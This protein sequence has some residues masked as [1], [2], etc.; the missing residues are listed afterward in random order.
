MYDGA[1][2][3]LVLKM[4]QGAPLFYLVFGYWM[5]SSMQLI[6]NSNLTPIKEQGDTMLTGHL[7]YQIFLPSGWYAP[8]YPLLIAFLSLVTLKFVLPVLAKRNSDSDFFNRFGARHQEKLGHY[9]D[10]VSNKDIEWTL[11]EELACR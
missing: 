2:H 7:Y 11:E 5:C 10:L 6:S 3:D 1:L 8:A 4:L 9:W